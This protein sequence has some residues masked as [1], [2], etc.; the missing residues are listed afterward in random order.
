MEGELCISGW[1]VGCTAAVPPVAAEDA[2][3][4][5]LHTNPTAHP[6]A[7]RLHE[8]A[9]LP[10]EL[11]GGV[12]GG[13]CCWVGLHLL[14]FWR[15]LQRCVPGDELRLRRCVLRGCMLR[16]ECSGMSTQKMRARWMSSWKGPWVGWGWGWKGY[17][18]VGAGAC[19]QHGRPQLVDRLPAPLLCV[20][21]LPGVPLQRSLKMGP[22]PPP[23]PRPRS[24]LCPRRSWGPATSSGTWRA[25]TSPPSSSGTWRRG[26]ARRA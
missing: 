17:W 5:R 3:P 10:Q 8:Q 6:P 25:A 14:V 4:A 22:T 13:G 1:V 2:P 9:H 24:H 16:N 15:G 18:E 23:T 12:Q 19:W 11:L 7:C 26:S 21:H 20:R